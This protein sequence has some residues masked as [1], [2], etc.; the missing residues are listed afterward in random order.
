MHTMGPPHPIYTASE[1]NIQTCLIFYTV[2][3]LPTLLILFV[4]LL[5]LKC[6]KSMPNTDGVAKM[7]AE[8]KYLKVQKGRQTQ[9]QTF[10]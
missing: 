7:K 9:L 2:A 4:A 8:V 5:C 3:L 10:L 6:N 1:C